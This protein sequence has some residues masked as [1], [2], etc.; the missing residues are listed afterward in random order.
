MVRLVARFLES[1]VATANLVVGTDVA[2]TA[3]EN[4]RMTVAP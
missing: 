1:S 3:S 4:F 2:E